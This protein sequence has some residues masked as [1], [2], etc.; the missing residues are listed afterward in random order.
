MHDSHV[1]EPRRLCINDVEINLL[2]EEMDSMWT[3]TQEEWEEKIN[4]LAA[5]IKLKTINFS[6]VFNKRKRH[7]NGLVSLL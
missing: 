1:N 4:K 7:S 6:H 3:P 2:S 5:T